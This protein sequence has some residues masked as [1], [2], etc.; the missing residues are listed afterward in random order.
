MEVVPVTQS[1]LS[2]TQGGAAVDCSLSLVS[3]ISSLDREISFKLKVGY[4]S[5]ELEQFLHFDFTESR[6]EFTR[7]R[8]PHA[9]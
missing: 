4:P 6:L 2:Y 9:F 3:S 5:L 7:E 8:A 1:T